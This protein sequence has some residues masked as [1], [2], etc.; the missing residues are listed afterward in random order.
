M[1]GYTSSAEVIEGYSGM[2]DIADENGFVVAYPQ[3]T[4]IVG[5]ILFSML[6]TIFTMQQ[7][8][9]TLDISIL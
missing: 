7:M 3:G 4:K 8:L 6:A 2:N 9:M 1:H 5:G